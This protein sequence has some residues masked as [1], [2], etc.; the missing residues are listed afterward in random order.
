MR[1]PPLA[2][3][4]G[5]E[6]IFGYSSCTLVT[7]TH[8]AAAPGGH[9]APGRPLGAQERAVEVH[10]QDFPPAL[11]PH[12][13]QRLV[14]AGARVVHQHAEPAQLAGQLVH[15]RGG[16]YGVGQVVL[17]DR[18]RPPAVADEAGGLLR[19]VAVGAV[20]DADVE[21]LLG[22]RHGG[23][24]ADAGVGSRDDGHPVVRV[25][26]GSSRCHRC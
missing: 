14:A 12:L 23:G 19:A 26:H 5:P 20:G 7:L 6:P 8:P 16:P 17:P 13:Q 1:S 11:V 9:H 24:L 25:V 10:R 22:Q 3:Q 18:G 21:A 4:Y 15:D 2:A